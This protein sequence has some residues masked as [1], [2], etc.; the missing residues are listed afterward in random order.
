MNTEKD[1]MNKQ[2]QI[3]AA[4]DVASDRIYEV[5]VIRD[6]IEILRKDQEEDFDRFE[7]GDTVLRSI[8]VLE[9][10][11]GD[12]LH[13]I[14]DDIEFMGVTLQKKPVTTK[15]AKKPS[16]LVVVPAASSGN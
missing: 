8:L 16:K 12:K 10:V 2:D 9:E 7:D 15:K 11:V 13:E 1:N 4:A 3:A 6:L 5:S 14:W